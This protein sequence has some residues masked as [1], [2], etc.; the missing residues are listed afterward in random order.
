MR[1]HFSWYIL[2]NTCWACCSLPG[3]HGCLIGSYW[4]GRQIIVR[5]VQFVYGQPEN[6]KIWWKKGGRRFSVD[7]SIKSLLM[8]LPLW[9]SNKYK[10]IFHT[11]FWLW[12]QE[13]NTT[14][15]QRIFMVSAMEL[16]HWLDWGSTFLFFF[17]FKDCGIKWVWI[18]KHSSEA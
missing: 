5:C 12:W 14:H 3:I 6:F 11:K 10:A 8:V 9:F 7:N 18:T 13:G 2:F 1:T 4:N 16:Q 15:L 17:N